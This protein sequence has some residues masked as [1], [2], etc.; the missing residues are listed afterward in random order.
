MKYET[1]LALKNAGFPL[2][3]IRGDFDIPHV[4][5]EG[6]NYGIPSLEELIEACGD[7]FHELTKL[8]HQKSETKEL[9]EASTNICEECGWD[10]YIF[11]AGRSAEEAIAMLYL[12]IHER[13]T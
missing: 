13:K 11:G 10:K 1:A 4:E 9:W 5:I 6:V 7:S 3:D 8:T 2:E 12:K